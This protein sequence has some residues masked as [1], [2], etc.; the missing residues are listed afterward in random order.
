[1]ARCCR[2][3]KT[4]QILTIGE[5]KSRS[6]LQF[7]YVRATTKD[8]AVED[9][10]RQPRSVPLTLLR[11][12]MKLMQIEK[13]MGN[14]TID[15]FP[16]F[17]SEILRKFY[18]PRRVKGLKLYEAE[19]KLSPS[20]KQFSRTFFYAKRPW[21]SILSGSNNKL[22]PDRRAFPRSIRFQGTGL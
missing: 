21:L 15:A 17:I 22:R 5:K 20:L 6:F 18:V 19:Q 9:D 4:M 13:R 16:F 2:S 12:T 14:L 11:R 8:I 7:F 3:E 10:R 1:M